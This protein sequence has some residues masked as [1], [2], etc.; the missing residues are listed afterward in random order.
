MTSSTL[1]YYFLKLAALMLFAFPFVIGWAAASG[2]LA[3]ESGGTAPLIEVA[4][5]CLVAPVLGWLIWRQFAIVECSAEGLQVRRNGRSTSFGWH[6]VASV[7]QVP[8]CTPPVYRICFKTDEPPAYC[9]FFSFIVVTIG[10][11]SWDFSGFLSYAR[12][13]ITNSEGSLKIQGFQS[14]SRP[15]F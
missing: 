14:P 13:N 6:E 10:F 2:Q 9:I 5:V 12:S 8:F 3:D 4:V 1:Y 7:K 11:W 15:P